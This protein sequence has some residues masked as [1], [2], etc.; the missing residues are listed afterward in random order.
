MKRKEKL[1]MKTDHIFFG[2]AYYDEYLPYDRID[3]DFQMM[4]DAGMN[5]IRIAESTWSTL[6]P[7]EGI[8]DFTHL[9][10]MLDAASRFGLSVIIGTPTY[11]IPAWL[12]KKS[13]DILALTENGQELYG[14]RQNMDLT[15]PVYL[16]YAENIIRVLMEHVSGHPNV[17]GYQ[18]D[19]ET[20]HYHT[21]G[22]RVQAMFVDY[23]KEQFPDIRE[24]NHEFGLDYWSNRIDDWA[25]F[26][27]V[28]GTINGSLA[29]EYARFQRKLVADFH[30]F[31][32]RIIKEY[33][34]PGQFITHNFDFAWIGHSFGIQPDADPFASSPSMDAAGADIYHPSQDNLT[35]AE[36][37][38]C[39]N[40]ARALKRDN[41]LILETQAQGNPQWLPYPGQLRLCAYSHLANGAN[42]V[43]Y[44]HWH[45][46]HNSFE[47][48]W[49]GVLS[50][51]FSENETYREAS[52][53]GAELK[54]IGDKLKNLR[55]S[56]HT[57]IL[58]SHES[59][60]GLSQFPTGDLKEQSYNTIF[61]WIADSL[62]RNNIEYD[63]IHPQNMH[64]NAYRMVFVP[65][66]YSAGEDTL[67][68]LKKYTAEG[69]HLIVTFRSAFSDGH[70][71]IYHDTQPH[72]LAECLGIHYDQFTIP[73]NVGIDCHFGSERENVP[74]REWLELVTTDG[75]ASLAAYRHDAW[76]RYSAVT[77][78][79]YQSGRA[80]YIGCYFD[81]EAAI[82]EL[83]GYIAVRADAAADVPAD[84]LA[85][86]CSVAEPS[87]AVCQPLLKTRCRFPIIVKR[88]FNDDGKEIIYYLNYSRK[89]QTVSYEGSDAHLLLSEG[90]IIRHG[91]TLTLK[92]WG[93]EIL[94]ISSS[95]LARITG[96]YACK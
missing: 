85:D 26:P 2:A 49:K 93:V 95:V 70:M 9:D 32:A 76:G 30:H 91:D 3:R 15:S 80:Y 14:R 11:A 53:F 31:Q 48:Y 61:R 35:G 84:I 75:A 10:R 71:K 88:G 5:T 81:D 27:D 34:K 54:K 23:L 43:M 56:N 94:E 92:P 6:E 8:Y 96:C 13:P 73:Q 19:N 79:A 50:H 22:P 59:L 37:T 87:P 33:R 4:K 52:Q 1:Y 60:S 17:I 57:A 28:R 39:G 69:G 21:A 67:T 64:L 86:R 12:A 63:I 51:D 90:R 74:V 25:D 29:A 55:K 41:Y 78:H 44:W 20:H 65:C 36:I 68:A 62:H 83:T 18:I 89:E 42:S 58:V 77:E 82:D 47:S 45:S 46:I 38:A 72:I 40:I 24:F 7:S 16:S 66:L